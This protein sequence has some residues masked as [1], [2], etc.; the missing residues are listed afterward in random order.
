MTILIAVVG[1]VATK[2]IVGTLITGLLA[3]GA[4][5]C[6]FETPEERLQAAQGE[7]YDGDE[8]HRPGQNCL[9][10]HSVDYSPGDDIFAVAGTVYDRPDDVKGLE[11][12]EVIMLDSDGR[13][14]SVLTN[15]VGNFMVEA[16]GD[17]GGREVSGKLKL[18]F[19]P[20][21]PLWVRVQHNGQEREMK[22]PIWQAGGC[23]HCHKKSPDVD[24]EVRV[25]L[26]EAG[27]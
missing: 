1:R 14:F 11:G 13:E 7:Y 19:D 16:G 5:G 20:T 10:C 22:S 18:L 23:A 12:A 9:I 25:F 3:I 26:R 17:G 21:F 27:Q 15:S 4:A 8:K 24:A 2:S 6:V